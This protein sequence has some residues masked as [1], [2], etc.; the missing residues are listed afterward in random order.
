MTTLHLSTAEGADVADHDGM[1]EA[2]LQHGSLQ[3]CR[4]GHGKGD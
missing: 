2:G 3:I 4:T 1:P